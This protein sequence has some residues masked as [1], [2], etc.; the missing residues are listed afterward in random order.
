MEPQLRSLAV[1]VR[2]GEDTVVAALNV[3]TFSY[4]HTRQELIDAY[5]PELREAARQLERAI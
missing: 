1:P 2:N 3:A 4:A 5:Q